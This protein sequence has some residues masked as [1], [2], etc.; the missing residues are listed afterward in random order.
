M[1]GQR[2]INSEFPNTFLSSGQFISILGS[3][4]GELGGSR[5]LSLQK[6]DYKGARPMIDLRMESRLQDAVLTG[7][8]GGLIQSARPIGRGGIATTIARCF[9]KTSLLGARI[10]FS[11]KLKVPELLFGETQGLIL[12]T[13]NEIDLM[14]FERVCM[15]IGVPATTIGRVTHDGQ[16]KFNDSIRLSVDSLSK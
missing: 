10:H 15:T 8:H 13:I 14:E 11:R 3:H 2:I 7:I 9:S 1:A 6:I 12:V 16:Y 5:Y 4:R